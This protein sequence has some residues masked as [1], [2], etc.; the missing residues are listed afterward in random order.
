MR[1][2]RIMVIVTEHYSERYRE[3]VG[4][5][6]ASA[7][8]AWLAKSLQARRPIRTPDGKFRLKLLGSRHAA[9]LV[10]E[11]RVWVGVTVE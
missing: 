2:D 5:A 10:R 3:R 4:S 9:V 11:N 7:Q 6:P 1:R 8:R